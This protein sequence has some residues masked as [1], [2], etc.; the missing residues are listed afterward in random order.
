MNQQISEGVS[1][2]DVEWLT[3]S[4]GSRCFYY[5]QSL[6]VRLMQ[7]ERLS[8]GETGRGEWMSEGGKHRQ[9]DTERDV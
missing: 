7:T 2:S 1:H 9:A 3:F 8:G 4:C 5:K 6:W